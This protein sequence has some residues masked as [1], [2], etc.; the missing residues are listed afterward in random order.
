MAEPILKWPGGKAWAKPHLSAYL[1]PKILDG[2]AYIEPF[3]GSGALAF[4]LEH[5]NTIINDI[6]PELINLYKVVA[7]DPE[8]LI[9]ELTEFAQFHSDKFY[10]AVRSWDQDPN[11]SSYPPVK[12]AARTVYLNKT[13]F[14]GLYRVNKKGYFN[15][16]I[17]RTT[18]GKM[19]DIVQADKIRR[20][21]M[22]LKQG[23]RILNLD[24]KEVIKS[25]QLG[26]IIFLDPPY[27][28]F[29]GKNGFVSYA[30]DGW[31][32]DDLEELRNL[33][34]FKIQQGC[35]IILTN[36]ATPRVLELFSTPDYHI[37]LVDVKRSINSKGDGRGAVKEVIIVDNELFSKVNNE[38]C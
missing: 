36:N 11:F 34:N 4:N 28:S 9:S 20:L 19:P 37:D 38:I 15:V 35:H 13:G 21:S 30:K 8:A 26:D 23:V 2:H 16:P 10:Y 29:P 1:S 5:Q 6:N 22:Y 31:T 32:D 14:N 33:C 27:S 3:I 12:R 17:G 25:A 24:Y 7:T 18:S